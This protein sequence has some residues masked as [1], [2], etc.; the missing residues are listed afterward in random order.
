MP[1]SFEWLDHEETPTPSESVNKVGRGD[2]GS[3]DDAKVPLIDS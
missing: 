2:Y 1:F 3:D